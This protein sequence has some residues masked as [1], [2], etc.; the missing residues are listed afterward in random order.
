[1][2]RKL[3]VLGLVFTF[4]LQAGQTGKIAGTVRDA[5]TGEILA[6]VNIVI[7]E[8]GLGGASDLSGRFFILN[9]PPWTFTVSG[10]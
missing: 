10:S 8:L 3:L 2:I 9:R 7:P 1:M 5:A 4:A 6:G